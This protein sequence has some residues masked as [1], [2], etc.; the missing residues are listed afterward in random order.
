MIMPPFVGTIGIKQI[1]GQEGRSMRSWSRLPDEPAHPIDWLGQGG[2]GGD[3]DERAASLPVLYLNVAA[4][5]AN[6]DP[7]M[8][9]AR[10]IWAAQASGNSAAS[11]FR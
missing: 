2:S 7:A 6:V 9:E 3:R 4:A 10:R 8:E 1:L 5:L 11:R